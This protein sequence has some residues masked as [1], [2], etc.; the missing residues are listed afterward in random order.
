MWVYLSTFS[1]FFLDEYFRDESQIW[2]KSL[3]Q[4]IYKNLFRFPLMVIINYNVVRL[5]IY[6]HTVYYIYIYTYTSFKDLQYY[7]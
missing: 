5:F 3:L 1:S 7:W 6:S 4:T 2:H